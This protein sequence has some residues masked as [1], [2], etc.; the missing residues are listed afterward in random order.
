[1]A[2]LCEHVIAEAEGLAGTDL[3]ELN[4]LDGPLQAFAVTCG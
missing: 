2:F 4:R 3:D 1:M